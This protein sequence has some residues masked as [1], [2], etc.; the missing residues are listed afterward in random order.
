MRWVLVG[1]LGVGGLSCG[2][3]P[4]SPAPFSYE[5]LPV[6]RIGGVWRGGGRDGDCGL[7]ADSTYY[8]RYECRADDGVV[9]SYTSWGGAFGTDNVAYRV[10]VELSKPATIEAVGVELK[11]KVPGAR[12]W[13]SNG[14]QSW[15]QSGALAIGPEPTEPDTETALASFGD[16]ETIR[17]GAALSW[18]YTAVGGGETTLVAGVASPKARKAWAQVWR[19]PGETDQVHLRLASGGTGPGEALPAG[20]TVEAETWFVAVD[21]LEKPALDSYALEVQSTLSPTRPPVATMLGWNS[22][23]EFWDSTDEKNARAN[24][25]LAKTALDPIASSAGKWLVIDDSWQKAW[26]D[27]TPNG[28]FPSGIDGLAKDVKAEGWHFGVWLAPFLVSDKLD[29]VKQHPD[30]FL[31]GVAYLH[32]KNG[33]MKILDVT[34]PDAAKHLHDVIEQLASWGC[35]VLKIDFLFAGLYEAPR[36]DGKS[37]PVQSYRAALQIIRDVADKHGMRLVAVGAPP[38]PTLEYCDGW[39]SGTDI[40]VENFGPAW[41]F[42]PNQL[43]DFAARIPYCQVIACDVD[44]PI[45]RTPL[46]PNEVDFGLWTVAFAAGGYF[47]SDDL[48]KLPTDRLAP[49]LDAKRLKLAI[50]GQL[51]LPTSIFPD[52]PPQTLAN[53]ILDQIALTTTQIVPPIWNTPDGQR[54]LMNASDVTATIDGQQV[55]PHSAFVK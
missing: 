11:V 30:W 35:E 49:G 42:L 40:A 20:S 45:L 13:I 15:S 8:S 34:N 26:G 3:E 1:L 5:V 10:R 23:Y 25:G 9:V 4:R 31:P 41:A 29:L 48:Q 24:F 6:V 16:A 12:S 39:R 54:V 28:K 44:P 17:D 55:P 32:L 46:P 52:N 33:S 38:V 18:W 2:S 21:S 14:F 22:W 27:W 19:N 51:S 53:A 7:V 50:G 37:S 43:R 47:L 36:F